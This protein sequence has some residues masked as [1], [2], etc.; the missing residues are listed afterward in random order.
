M[1]WVSDC[2]RLTRVN[3][4]ARWGASFSFFYFQAASQAH[5]PASDKSAQ[6]RLVWGAKCEKVSRRLG[7][8]KAGHQRDHLNDE[9]RA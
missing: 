3:L 9:S 7:Q 1:L 6:E 8:P 4:H 5:Q 2:L